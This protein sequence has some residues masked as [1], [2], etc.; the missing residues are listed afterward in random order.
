M[1]SS[2]SSVFRQTVRKPQTRNIRSQF[3][4]GFDLFLLL[5]CLLAET[6]PPT[7]VAFSPLVLDAA[8]L[9]TAA[10]YK[11]T[12]G[13]RHANDFTQQVAT[14]IAN[15]N[16]LTASGH[17]TTTMAMTLTM[18]MTMTKTTNTVTIQQQARQQ[19]AAVE[20]S[21][22]QEQGSEMRSRLVSERRVKLLP[23]TKSDWY[24]IVADHT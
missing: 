10:R 7:P 4:D 1:S 11:H 14:A 15:N 6:Y 22:Q 8:R 19:A 18:T 3:P 5:R 9:S 21:E 17:R 20:V 24:H 12:F 23:T 13:R 2:T 16:G